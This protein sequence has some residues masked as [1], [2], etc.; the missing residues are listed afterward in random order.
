MLSYV[1]I[2]LLLISIFLVAKGQYNRMAAIVSKEE[3]IGGMALNIPDIIAFGALYFLAMVNKKNTA[4]HMRYMI[5]TSLLM[6]GPGTG[7]VLII[8][9]GMSFPQGI[10][11]SSFLTELVTLGLIIYD[12][13]KQKPYKPYLVTLLILIGMHLIWEFQLSW[14]W[15][16]FAGKFAALF[17]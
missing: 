4:Y 16:A 15:Q 6:L 10:E 17:F 13:V 7:R 2:P 9:G 1:I 8:Y 12:L 11:Y 14:W 3:N 5:A